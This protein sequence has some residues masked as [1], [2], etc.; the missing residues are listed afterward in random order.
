MSY[1]LTVY[2]VD[3]AKITSLFGS[4]NADLLTRFTGWTLE[5]IAED[6]AEN[7][8][9][10][11]TQIPFLDYEPHSIWAV[12]DLIMGHELTLSGAEYAYGYGDLVDLRGTRLD[13][14]LFYPASVEYL[15]EEIDPELAAAGVNLTLNDLMFGGALVRFPPPED[16]PAMGHWTAEKVASSVAPLQA[17]SGTRPEIAAIRDWC[18]AAAAAGETIVAFYS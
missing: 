8:E 9:L 10:R 18:E 15:S 5:D 12:R 13:N 1:G 2:R 3:A 14:S 4:K 17:Y 16:F 7:E 6:E 11:S